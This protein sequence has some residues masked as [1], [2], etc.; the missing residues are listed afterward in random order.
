MA[1]RI[2]DVADS[3]IH[4]VVLQIHD[5]SIRICI[6]RLL[7]LAGFDCNERAGFDRE[8]VVERYVIDSIE[9]LAG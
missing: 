8:D 3:E 9:E 4:S 2:E 6:V 5:L 1:I 7:R